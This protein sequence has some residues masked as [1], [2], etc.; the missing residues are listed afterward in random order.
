MS[1]HK[2]FRI[3]PGQRQATLNALLGL[4]DAFEPLPERCEW[5]NDLAG[6]DHLRWMEI[7]T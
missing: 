4:K 3:K 5:V 2:K 1:L 6:Y 7:L